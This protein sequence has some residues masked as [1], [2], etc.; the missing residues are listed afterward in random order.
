MFVAID[1]LPWDALS[2]REPEIPWV[3]LRALADAA[4]ESTDVL[5]RLLA[6]HEAYYCRWEA[7]HLG[8][9]VDWT[10]LSDTGILAVLDL[11]SSRFDTA[12]RRLV[13][14]ALVRRAFDAGRY[15]D[16]F[17][18][19]DISR[20]AHRLR[21]GPVE[22]ALQVLIEHGQDH[23]GWHFVYPMLENA[24]A[25]DDDL[26]RRVI[27]FCRS[28]IDTLDDL[29]SPWTSAMFP[30]D[31]LA[32]LNDRDSIPLLERAYARSRSPDIRVHL[33]RLKGTLPPEEDHPNHFLETPVEK[34][35]PQRLEL[36][37]DWLRR[38]ESGELDEEFDSD[39]D[40][41]D[42]AE[43][44]ISTSALLD[45][46]GRD[47]LT[48]PGADYL[49]NDTIAT[50][51]IRSEPRVGRNEPCPCGSGKKYKKCCGM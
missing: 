1:T 43:P 44:E 17:G 36:H 15:D 12:A 33:R 4:V 34:W 38:L 48:D 21:E 9:S 13:G 25:A 30:A 19:E 47:P 22:P 35:L 18:L 26:R 11:A 2:L 41:F 40:D 45:R 27:E 31:V 5:N 50:P 23:P 29:T 42:D 24:T 20:V 46:H 28:E 16:E 14:E 7:H 10:D 6:Q 51:I 49:P 37:R 3:A 32:A 39:V 8:T